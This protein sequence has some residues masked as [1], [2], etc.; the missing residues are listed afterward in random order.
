MYGCLWL[1]NHSELC[2]CGKHAFHFRL[3]RTACVRLSGHTHTLVKLFVSKAHTA[4]NWGVIVLVSAWCACIW[5]SIVCYE[6]MEKRIFNAKIFPGSCNIMTFRIGSNC[7]WIGWTSIS[8]LLLMVQFVASSFCMGS[9]SFYSYHSYL[10]YNHA[11]LKVLPRQVCSRSLYVVDG[12]IR[13]E[14]HIQNFI[15]SHRERVCGVVCVFFFF[16]SLFVFATFGDT[17]RVVLCSELVAI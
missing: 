17:L 2:E 8:T 13:S 3:Q 9:D 1:Y 5:P 4:H 10:R 12:W 15:V 16:F 11:A 14:I 6:R 7:N